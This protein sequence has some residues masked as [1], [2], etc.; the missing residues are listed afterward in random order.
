[1]ETAKTIVF[2]LTASQQRRY[3]FGLAGGASMVLSAGVVRLAITGRLMSLAGLVS[4]SVLALALG[5]AAMVVIGMQ[6]LVVVTETSL[7]A[8]R[9][10]RRTEVTWIDVTTIDIR[11][12]GESRRVVVHANGRPVVL[13][14]P[15]TGGSLLSPGID[16]DL[17]DKVEI[18]RGWWRSR[19]TT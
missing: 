19:A 7:L 14:V 8:R 1:V 4:I 17:D 15:L 10:P 3:R 18:L 16:R 11:E 2:R 13:P 12:R 5:A 9:G 6:P